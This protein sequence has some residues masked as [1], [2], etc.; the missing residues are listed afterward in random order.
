MDAT[1][2]IVTLGDSVS[3]GQGLL[4]QH[5]FA[6]LVADAFGASSVGN[7]FILAHSG[8]IIGVSDPKTTTSINPE[9][10]APSPMIIDQVGQVQSPE[11][12]DLVL[13][14]GGINDVNITTIFNPL[15]ALADLRKS[16]LQFCYTDMKALLTKALK[17]FT[18]PTVEIRVIGYYPIVSFVSNPLPGPAGDPLVHFLGNFNLGFPQTL[19][20]DAILGAL[21]DRAMQFWGDSTS[22]LQRAVNEIANASLAFVKSPFTPD[23]A[24]FTPDSMLWGFG[25]DLGPE[26]E[27]AVQREA[28]CAVQYPPLIEFIANE[29]CHLAS[30]G[31]PKV[32]GAQAISAAILSTL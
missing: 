14:T 1:S 16:T 17:T 29:V 13:L 4:T 23:N 15:T 19:E 3:W 8:A 27:V 12:V 30:V 20:R 5:K 28:A 7:D 2:R 21:S 9:I 31:H 18:K 24:L 32:T 10:P 6:S 11:T 25:N 22:Y 26:D